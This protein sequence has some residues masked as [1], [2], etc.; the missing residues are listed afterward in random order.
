[1]DKVFILNKIHELYNITVTS[2]D[3]VYNLDVEVLF[4]PKDIENPITPSVEFCSSHFYLD[5]K[6]DDIILDDIEF[7]R[8]IYEKWGKIIEI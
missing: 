3:D 6:D 2:Q 5:D 8:Y 1:M 7:M 4:E